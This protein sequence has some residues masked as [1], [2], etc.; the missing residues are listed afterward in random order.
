MTITFKG[1]SI[2]FVIAGD[3]SHDFMIPNNRA[4]MPTKTAEA[5]DALLAAQKNEQTVT[6]KN[7]SSATAKQESCEATR[8]VLNDLYD[9][10]SA[11]TGSRRLHHEEQY[12][13]AGAK[14]ARALADAEAA[15]QLLADH[16]L[17]HANPVGVGFD[18]GTRSKA[19]AR[20]R[21]LAAELANLS[22]VPPI[23]A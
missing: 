20:L 19:V 3:R 10:A 6:A 14:F 22:A 13:F 9:Q 17:Q 8:Q 15:L 5:L 16:A 11:T 23:D 4:T 21:C 1:E 18:P 12:A 2:S 7:N